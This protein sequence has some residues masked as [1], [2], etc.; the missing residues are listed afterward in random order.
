MVRHDYVRLRPPPG[1]FNFGQVW[2]ASVAFHDRKCRA[3]D[4]ASKILLIVLLVVKIRRKRP[5]GMA[6]ISARESI[7]QVPIVWFDPLGRARLGLTLADVRL[8][9]MLE[10]RKA[11]RCSGA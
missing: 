5:V 4:V 2:A 7:E 9:P 8:L 3:P 10:G 11:L 6:E 1:L